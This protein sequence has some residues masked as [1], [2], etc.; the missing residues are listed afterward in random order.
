MSDAFATKDA[1]AIYRFLQRRE[2]IGGAHPGPI[3]A[4]I[5]DAAPLT[6]V[7]MIE[8]CM[9]LFMYVCIYTFSYEYMYSN[10]HI[11]ISI[12]IHIYI[13]FYIHIY[14]LIYI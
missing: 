9:Y 12:Y 3:A 5:R 7:E 10:K 14:L 2:F 4:L 8:V 13:S 1:K 11:S 6:G